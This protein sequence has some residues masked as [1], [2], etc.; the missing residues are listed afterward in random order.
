MSATG[1]A[2]VIKVD[3]S[4]C[5]NCHMC[6]AVCP[7]K[8]CIDGSGEKVQMN[9]ELCIGCGR[10]IE[11]CTHGARKGIDDMD[12]FMDA[13][14]RK[15]P[16]IALVAPAVAA[17]YPDDWK[18]FNGWLASLGVRAIFDVSF[19][20]ELTVESYLRYID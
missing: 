13:V 17:K 18:R 3:E 7:V 16:M 9:H 10:C 19:G 4:L 11:A 5:V 20:A 2:P 15:Q 12:A 14:R 8:I 6:I 1:L